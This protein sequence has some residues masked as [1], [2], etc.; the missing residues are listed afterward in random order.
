MDGR[1]D[2][3]VD[4]ACAPAAMAVA[5]V[6]VGEPPAWYDRA[7]CAGMGTARFFPSSAD[8]DNWDQQARA[9]CSICP[10]RVECLD[11]ALAHGEQGIWGGVDEHG[12][13]R[14]RRAWRR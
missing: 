6:S 7:A 4:R 2:A 12:R 13:V 1:M 8:P 3:D 9:A 5:P 10:V 14:L 11:W